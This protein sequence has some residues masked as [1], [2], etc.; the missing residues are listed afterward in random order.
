MARPTKKGL[1]YFPLDVDFFEDEKMLAISGEFSVKGE[2]V[3]L[4]LL[5]EIYRNG[6]FVEYSELLKN[7]LARLSGLSVGLID[8]VTNKLVKYNFFNEG[9]FRE[10]NVL[11]SQG[12]QK[13][14]EEA[15]KRRKK[16][17]CKHY[18]LLSGVNVY[19]NP[20]LKE[21]NAT[22]TTQSKVKES[23]V[24]ETKTIQKVVDD[25]FVVFAGIKYPKT[26]IHFSEKLMDEENAL[27]TFMMQNK[28]K[29]MNTV[30]TRLMDFLKHLNIESKTYDEASFKDFKKHFHNWFRRVKHDVMEDKPKSKKLPDGMQ[31]AEWLA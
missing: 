17:L 7:K 31:P 28:I 11:T 9:V 3:A 22:L 8:E 12:I 1:D 16:H 19:N 18:W 2:M 15:S 21:D 10:H 14:F 25:D 23:K 5:C 24:K 6:Y 27:A 20:P 29:S 4:R 13:R 30:K 26:H